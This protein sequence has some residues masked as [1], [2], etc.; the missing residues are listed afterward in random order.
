MQNLNCFFSWKDIH[1]L[2]HESIFFHEKCIYFTKR[3]FIF[4]R[5]DTFLFH[6]TIFYFFTKRYIFIS[7]NDFIFYFST[8]RYIFISRNDFIFYFFTKRL[9]FLFFSLN[10]IDLFYLNFMTRI[11]TVSKWQPW[12]VVHEAMCYYN[13][14]EGNSCWNKARCKYLINARG[15][16]GLADTKWNW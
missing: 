14:W 16:F 8:K 13:I 9:I 3:F 1:I 12:T 2:F 15:G 10:K 6:E 7:R 5:N 11:K 4:S